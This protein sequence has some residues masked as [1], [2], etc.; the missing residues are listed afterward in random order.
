M[1]GNVLR[2]GGRFNGANTVLVFDK[3]NTKMKKIEVTGLILKKVSQSYDGT[4][5]NVIGRIFFEDKEIAEIRHDFFTDEFFGW[6][7]LF[8]KQSPNFD[9]KF[10]LTSSTKIEKYGNKNGKEA[11]SIADE[12][13]EL[14]FSEIKTKIP[15]INELL[16]FFAKN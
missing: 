9:Q 15:L 14:K 13:R 5:L 2:I 1:A 11:E 4:S 6:I 12:M 8:K 7:S 16:D 3:K 10:L